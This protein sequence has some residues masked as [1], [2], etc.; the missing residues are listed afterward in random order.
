MKFP[1]TPQLIDEARRYQLRS[2]CQHC[3]FWLAARGACL[4]GWPD[5]GQRRW[6]LDAP[7]ASGAAP[8]D[9]AFCKEFELA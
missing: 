2:A 5:E 4:H 3:L 9:A 1:L 8:T 6:P 7:D